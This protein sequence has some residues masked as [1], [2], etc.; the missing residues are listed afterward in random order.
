MTGSGFVRYRKVGR[1]ERTKDGGLAVTFAGTFGGEEHLVV[2]A[3][4]ARDLLQHRAGADLLQV[5][6]GCAPVK[7]GKAYRSRSGKALIITSPTVNGEMM[8]PWVALQKVAS[9]I[10]RYAVLSIQEVVPF[11][12]APARA[13]EV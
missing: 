6:P 11:Q 4:A 7:M 1:I 8:C 13:L 9:G 2:T 10:T 5:Q 12:M 3:T